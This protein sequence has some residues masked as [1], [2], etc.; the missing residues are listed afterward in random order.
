METLEIFKKAFGDKVEAAAFCLDIIYIA[1]F[2]DDLIDKDKTRTNEEINRAFEI[3][4]I[5]MPTNNFYQ[6]YQKAIMPMLHTTITA[7]YESNKRQSGNEED[8]FFAFFLRNILLNVVYFSYSVVGG[9]MQVLHDYF[10]KNMKQEYENFKV[11]D[12]QDA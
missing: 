6:E 10:A 11:E 3:L 9:N 5:G 7:W 4:L 12:K 2:W 1:H 8:K